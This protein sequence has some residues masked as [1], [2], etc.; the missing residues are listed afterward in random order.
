[1]AR[2]TA[3]LMS[4]ERRCV[5]CGTKC[6]ADGESGIIEAFTLVV[7]SE[8][9]EHLER[10]MMKARAD[11]VDQPCD[12]VLLLD[13]PI[14]TLLTLVLARIVAAV[15]L[16]SGAQRSLYVLT[17]VNFVL[18]MLPRV[19]AGYNGSAGTVLLGRARLDGVAYFGIGDDVTSTG[20][21]IQ[22][23]EVRVGCGRGSDSGAR[24]RYW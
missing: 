11:L 20:R 23:G 19:G 6:C 3:T 24:V 5:M 4:R 12:N 14:L 22:G 2:E 1:M 17:A 16:L 21:F 8:G 10:A 9:L 13:I 7:N 18:E 15:E